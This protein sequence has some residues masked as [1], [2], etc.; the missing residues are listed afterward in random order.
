MNSEKKMTCTM[1]FQKDPEGKE[2]LLKDGKFQVMMEWEKPYMEACIHALH[3]TGDVLEIGFGCGY[4]ASAIQS[5]KPRSHTI[6]EYHP[7]VAQKAREW[8]ADKEGVTIIEDTWQ[9]CVSSL[10]KFD[11]IF[12]DDYPL[13]SEK[14]QNDKVKEKQKAS[15]IVEK[16]KELIKKIQE[17]FSFIETIKYKDEDLEEFYSEIKKRKTLNKD[18]FLPFFYKLKI[19][20]QITSEQFERVKERLVEE[21]LIDKKTIDEFIAKKEPV[22]NYRGDR[23]FEFFFRCLNSH[24][25]YGGRFSCYLEHS[26][27]RYED[28]RFVKEIIENP[29]LDFEEHL[30]DVEVPKNCQYFQG[31]KACVMV[32]TNR[33]N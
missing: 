10:G 1:E 19:K 17:K 25:K 6:I 24:M 26:H 23:F 18:H 14:E 13:E 9:N 4:S 3:P 2:I 11:A 7:T 5:Y 31:S 21:K 30:I 28:D 15:F 20:E 33:V 29:F 22:A 16:G 27:S 32:I 8:A 12:F